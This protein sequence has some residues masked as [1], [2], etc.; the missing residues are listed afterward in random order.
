[1]RHMRAG[2]AIPDFPLAF[3]RLVPPLETFPVA[4]HYTHRLFALVVVASITWLVSRIWLQHRED[5]R[6]TAPAVFVAVLALLQI[7]LG[8]TIV[9]TSRAVLPAT[10]HVANGALILATTWLITL[11]ASIHYAPRSTAELRTAIA[12]ESRS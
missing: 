5:P 6:F 4:I 2:L 12:A 11:R 10:A 1:M 3:G 8:G 9:W 7:L